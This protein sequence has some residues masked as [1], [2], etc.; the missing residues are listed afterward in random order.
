MD[1]H[2]LLGIPIVSADVFTNKG[3]FVHAGNCDWS[4]EAEG[5][6]ASLFD[7]ASKTTAVSADPGVVVSVWCTI[8][9]VVAGVM[10]EAE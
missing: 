4:I 9:N 5:G 2:A 1:V 3:E 7:T 10:F 8:G 6:Q